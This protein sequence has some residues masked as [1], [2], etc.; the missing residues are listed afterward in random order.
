MS[1]HTGNNGAVFSGATEIGCITAYDWT[2]SLSNIDATCMKDTTAQSLAD[3]VQSTGSLS[4][5]FNDGDTGQALVIAGAEFVLQ[6][7]D[8]GETTGD[9]YDEV[10][11]RIMSVGK[12]SARGSVITLSGSWESTGALTREN[13]VA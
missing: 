4:M 1:R 13:A 10:P 2:E 9:T 12:S 11:I 3:I 8:D 7:Y 5:N 6:M